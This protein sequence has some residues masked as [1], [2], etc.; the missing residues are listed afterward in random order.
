VK[1]MTPTERL[2]KDLRVMNAHTDFDMI[3]IEQTNRKFQKMEGALVYKYKE[4]MNVDDAEN[5]VIDSIKGDFEG[6][7]LWLVENPYPNRKP[8]GT[9]LVAYLVNDNNETPENSLS[10]EARGWNLEFLAAHYDSG[11]FKVID[12]KWDSVVKKRHEAIKKALQ[13][14]RPKHKFDPRYNPKGPGYGVGE[15]LNLVV[16]HPKDVSTELN[17]FREELRALRKDKK[18]DKGMIAKLTKLLEKKAKPPVDEKVEAPIT[19]SF[20]G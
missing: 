2:A 18:E 16:E 14:D 5:P 10:G 4:T 15:K 6:G 12:P 8:V 1:E 19:A 20:G 3:E 7:T 13:T 11:L 9:G 17:E